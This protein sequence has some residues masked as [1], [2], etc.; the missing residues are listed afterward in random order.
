MANCNE[1]IKV[2]P[3][4]RCSESVYI[5]Q[6]NGPSDDTYLGAITDLSTGRVESVLAVA[7]GQ[8]LTLPIQFELMAGHVYEVKVYHVDNTADPHTVTVGAETSCCI[9]FQ[10]MEVIQGADPI[11]I[12]NVNDCNSATND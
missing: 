6:V 4:S 9:Q 12:F 2:N 10:T 1:C 7:D 11:A 3:I 5:P 8:S